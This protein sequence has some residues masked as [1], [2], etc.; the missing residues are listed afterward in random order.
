MKLI[1]K[2]AIVTGASRGL[3]MAIAFGLAQE[4]AGGVVAARSETESEKVI[5]TIYRTAEDIQAIGGRSIAVKCDVTQEN[6]VAAMVQRTL[7][8]FGRI[9]ILVN[10]AGI[11]APSSLSDMTLK[12]WELVLRVNLTGS[13]LCAKAVLPSMIKQKCGSIINVSSVQ[14]QSRGSVGTG[15]AYGVSKAAIE[16]FTIGLAME[17]GKYNIA[18]NCLKP[19]GAV[20]TEGMKLLNPD[21]DWSKWD[22]PDKLVKSTVFLASQDAQGVTGTIS[23]DEEICAFHGII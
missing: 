12:R 11:A 6:D 13:F 1:G 5:G 16:R 3:G 10:N 14:A 23:T 19:R 4:G 18:V 7:E 21:A 8:I 17:V 15:I 22:N 20:A 9:D 2:V